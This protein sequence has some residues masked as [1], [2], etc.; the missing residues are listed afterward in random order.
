[1]TQGDTIG[2]VKDAI[3]TALLVAAPF[4]IVTAVIGLLVSIIQAA[5]QIQEQSIAFILKIV[6]VG[7]LLVLLGPWLANTM[8]DYTTKT[9]ALIESLL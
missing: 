7:L 6:A 5:T 8:M 3:T 9:F 4:L 1:M 2:I